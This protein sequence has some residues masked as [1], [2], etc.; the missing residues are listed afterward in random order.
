M[1]TVEQAMSVEARKILK[2][3][4]ALGGNLVGVL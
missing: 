3:G 2:K 1:E 4:P